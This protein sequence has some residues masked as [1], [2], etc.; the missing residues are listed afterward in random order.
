M[1]RL[2]Q[3]II[4]IIAQKSKC[5]ALLNVAHRMRQSIVPISHAPIIIADLTSEIGNIGHTG[6]DS[7]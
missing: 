5:C 6:S 1:Y 2:I 7:S 4:A 3:S